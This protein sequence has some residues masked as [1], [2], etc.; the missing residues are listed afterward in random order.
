MR[1]MVSE[2]PP[3]FQGTIMRMGF[4]GKTAA[5]SAAAAAP[6]HEKRMVAITTAPGELV[7][8]IVIT[9]TPHIFS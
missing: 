3:G 2:V 5:L 4:F 8:S 1:A 7:F 9:N 6:A